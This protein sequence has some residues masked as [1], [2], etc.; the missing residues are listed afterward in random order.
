MACRIDK[1]IWCVRLSKTRSKASESIS[2]G[3]VLL[4]GEQVKPSREIKKGDKITILINTAQFTYEVISVLDK[5]VG[6]KLVSE[7]IKDMTPPEEIEKLRLYR[8]AQQVYREHGDGKPTK[9]D[10]R[11]LD[12][13]LNS[14]E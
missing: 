5:R 2:K 13:F 10:R 14:W 6:A 4:N 9:K 12:D 1:Y 3:R 11:S 7:Y 8:A